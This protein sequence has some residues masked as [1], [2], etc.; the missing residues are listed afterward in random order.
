MFEMRTECCSYI[1]SLLT[2][3]KLGLNSAEVNNHLMQNESE[4]F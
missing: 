1:E 3:N 4:K 2:Q